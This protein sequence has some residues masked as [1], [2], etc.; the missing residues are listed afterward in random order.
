MPPGDD[1]PHRGQ[2]FLVQFG[3]RWLKDDHVRILDVL[4]V[5]EQGKRDKSILIVGSLVHGVLDL[6]L[7][8]ADDFEIESPDA[9][10][11]P[12]ARRSLKDFPGSVITED[13]DP[14]MLQEV[15]FIEIAAV[16]DVD[17]AHLEHG[18]HDILG[19]DQT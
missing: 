15:R 7:H 8:H 2:R 12:D 1:L 3:G 11:L 19:L 4:E 17:L 16:C 10:A 9:D 18:A 5:A 6:V 14:V 13:D